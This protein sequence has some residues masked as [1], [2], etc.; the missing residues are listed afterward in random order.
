MEGNSTFYALPTPGAVSRWRDEVPPGFR[1]CFK[2][3]SDITHKRMLL[4]AGRERD[5]FL[6]LMSPLAA[7][8]GPFLIQLGPKFGATRLGTLRSFLSQLSSEF[9]YAV[10]V[11]H[12]DYFDG[13]PFEAALH[14]CLREFEVD[15]AV[16]DTRCIH[17]ATAADA[18]TVAA[19]ARK[20]SIPLRRLAI[21][22]RPMLR[23]VGENQATAAHTFLHEWLDIAVAWLTEGRDLHFFMHTPDDKEAPLLAR[24]FYD[25]VREQLK[26][27][28]LPAFPG[29]AAHSQL[30]L[31]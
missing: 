2:F 17:A 20:P 10:E 26:L 6:K 11:R 30:S 13:G 4:G 15:R 25:R 24:W 19:Q 18:N 16:M 27:P 8:L 3:P 12:P 9:Q 14:E 31:W 1:F 21:G 28:P 5:A 23:F 22:H 29:E 7:N